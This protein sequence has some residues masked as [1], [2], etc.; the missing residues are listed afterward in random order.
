MILRQPCARRPWL[1]KCV[2]GFSIVEA[3]IAMGIGTVSVGG[4]LVLNSHQLK[5]VKS[6]RDS[7]AASHSL[8]ERIE[9]LRIATWRQ[10]TDPIYIKDSFFATVPKSIGPLENFKETVTVSAWPIPDAATKIVV[11]KQ[12]GQAVSVLS[13]GVGLPLQR[14]ARIDVRV[15]WRGK[16]GRERIRELAT[17]ISNGGISR[18]NLPGMGAAAGAPE[19]PAVMP[20]GGTTL[21]TTSGDSST[22]T[23][24]TPTTTTTTTAATAASKGSRG[25]IGGRQ[26]KK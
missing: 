19:A 10:I 2:A 24:T 5:L 4:A 1:S 12:N 7:S 14:L 11:E 6:T 15:T 3:V 17:M 21:T 23:T 22:T 8:E 13:D 9:Q 16:D 18:M 26:G 25:T 20:I